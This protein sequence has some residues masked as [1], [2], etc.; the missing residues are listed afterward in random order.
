MGDLYH[1][2]WRVCLAGG[3]LDQPWCSKLHPGSVVVV[4]VH[5][6]TEFKTRSGLATSTRTVG[7]KLW[8][9]DNGGR[10]PPGADPLQ[11]ARLLF[12]C[13]NPIDC[14]Y[15]SGSQDALGLMVPGIS[16]L[17]YNGSYWPSHVESIHDERTLKWLESVLWLIPLPSR[18]DG[19][20]P[21]LVQHLTEENAAMIAE[22]SKLAWAGICERNVNTLGQGLTRTRQGWSALLPETVPKHSHAWF[23]D[24]LTEPYTGC[25]FSGAG[26][27]FL[28]VASPTETDLLLEKGFKVSVKSTPWLSPESSKL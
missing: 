28:M 23:A 11:L 26:G 21:L 25:L 3:W 12:N 24:F 13:E 22:G 6:Q 4:N 7:I 8:G 2:P 17:D 15:V 9:T 1:F 14:K 20:D 27:G 10:P 16:R 19:Y 18:P 5:P